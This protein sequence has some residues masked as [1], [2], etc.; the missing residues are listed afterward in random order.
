[1]CSIGQ[2]MYEVRVYVDYS[3][4]CLCYYSGRDML[5]ELVG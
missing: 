1:M 3:W 2:K 4:L 5:V